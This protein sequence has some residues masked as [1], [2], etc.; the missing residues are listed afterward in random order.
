MIDKEL[1]IF[2]DEL[3][4]FGKITAGITHDIKNGLA[5][6]KEEAGLASDLL[7]LIEK[8]NPPDFNRIIDLLEKIN[9]KIDQTDNILKDLN[10]FS[11]CVD[12]TQFV[13]DLNEILVLMTR[14]IKRFLHSQCVEL[15]VIQADE[16]LQIESNPFLLKRLLFIF[17]EETV[18]LSQKGEKIIIS[19]EKFNDSPC[20]AFSNIF[21]GPI[22]PENAQKDSFDYLVKNLNCNVVFFHEMKKMILSFPK[23][24]KLK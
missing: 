12:H 23:I 9:S 14:L 5:V 16:Q 24:M 11:H 8:G 1:E 4:F 2:W 15:E 18:K 6:I 13:F 20:F 19:V 7:K 21:S 22:K 3:I 17:I 10:Q